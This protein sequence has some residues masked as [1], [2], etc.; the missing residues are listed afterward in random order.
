LEVSSAAPVISVVVLSYNARA[1][2]DV[3][4]RALREQDLAEPYEVVVV[5]SGSDDCADHLRHVYPEVRV[6]RSERRLVPGEA[7]NRGWRAARGR[8]VAFLADDCAP[9][10][11]WLRLRVAKHRE[12]FPCVG[13]SIVNGT[14]RHPIG[15]A[16]Y[17]LEYSALI[18]SAKIL[19]EQTVPHSMSYERSLFERLG[20]FPEDTMTGE[21]TLFNSRC[22]KAGVPIGLQPH[23]QLAHRNLTG[24]RAYLRHQHAHGRGLLQ[25]VERHGLPSSTG[26]A[27][28]AVPLALWRM[29][30]VYPT[31]RWWSALKR[32]ARGRPEWATAYLALSPIVWAGLWATA[33][34]SWAEWRAQQR[35]ASS[36]DAGTS[37]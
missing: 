3:P 22:V 28:Q 24:L 1:R 35:A 26:P 4:L 12:G 11:E 6:V 18:P 32:I 17:Y 2:I 15:S 27:R 21:D 14:P 9:V 23:A 16:G 8:Y 5:D 20:D 31:G 10:P 7:R 34:G 25:C 37:R 29:F 30:L 33:S 19:A 36:S 13:G